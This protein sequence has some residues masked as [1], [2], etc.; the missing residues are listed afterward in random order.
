VFASLYLGDLTTAQFRGLARVMRDNG[1]DDARLTIRQNVVLRDVPADR[2][3]HLWAGLADLDLVRPLAEKSGDVVSCPGAETCNLAITASRGLGEAITR[4]LEAE[5]LDTVDGVRINIS[6]CPNS[7]GQH[8]AWD[9]GFSGLAVRDA[10]GNE[11]PGY[12]VYVGGHIA[13]GGAEFGDYVTK[14]P[15]KHAPTAAARIIR[16]FRDERGDGEAVWQWYA[17]TGK[18]EV[19]DLLDDL[20]ALPSKLDDPSYYVDLGNSSSFEVILGQ[21]ECIS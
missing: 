14:V 4:H 18:A 16:R 15:A 19:A 5:G 9:L 20:T 21:G 13:D 1:L 11:G 2:L 3:A 10:D 8:Q 6:G 7:C 17:R 12:R